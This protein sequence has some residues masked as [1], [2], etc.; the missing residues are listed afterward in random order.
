MSTEKV[1]VIVAVL[2]FVGA[3]YF[4]GKAIFHAYNAVTNITGKYANLLGPFALLSASQFN[5]KGNQ[6][7]AA[8]GPALLGLA[9]CWAT[10]FAIGALDVA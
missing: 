5:S 9:A 1:L 4:T 3:F 7:R 6:H 2:A 10:L 8:L